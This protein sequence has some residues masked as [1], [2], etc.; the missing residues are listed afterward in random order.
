M[1]KKSYQE[2]FISRKTLPLRADYCKAVHIDP[3]VVKMV[4]SLSTAAGV[5]MGEFVNTV[6]IDHFE[7][8]K[9]E[10]LD[11]IRRNIESI[12]FDSE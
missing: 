8:F 12:D 5:Y 2:R 10:I 4:K 1:S 9:P 7:K 11:I 3:K 6:L